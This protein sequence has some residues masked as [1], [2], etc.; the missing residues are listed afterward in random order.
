MTGPRRCRRV[1]TPSS[2]LRSAL[3]SS[4]RT[5]CASR[6]VS[7]PTASCAPAGP[8]SATTPIP[9]SFG[10]LAVGQETSGEEVGVDLGLFDNRVSLNATLYQKSTT[11]QILPVSIS[12]A[13]GDSQAVVNSGEVRN[14]G[15]ELSATM[16]PIE[17]P[18]FRWN[19]V[20][21]WS[22]NTNKVLSLYNGVQRI[23]VNSFWV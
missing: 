2:T 7:C 13:T 22:K 18:D 21:N 5:R 14:R 12:Q 8:A 16:T 4:S 6:A 11:N 20:V 9:T 3:L 19:V 10:Q 23:V 15:I 17:R 1:T